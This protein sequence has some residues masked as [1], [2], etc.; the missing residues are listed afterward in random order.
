LPTPIA[1]LLA[2]DPARAD[3][4]EPSFREVDAYVLAHLLA[5]GLALLMF[6]RDRGWHPAG[7]LMAALVFAFGAS[8][9]WRVQHVGQIASY[10]FFAIAFWLTARMLQRSSILSGVFAGLAAA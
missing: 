10:A 2:R 3:L 6:F 9:A 4:A 8:A 1:D 5:G 7:G